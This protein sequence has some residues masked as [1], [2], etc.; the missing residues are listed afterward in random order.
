M[1]D[2]NNNSI[3]NTNMEF[4]NEAIQHLNETRKWTM[5]LAIVGFVFLGLMLISVLIALAT[6]SNR[7]PHAGI[8]G[9][10][11]FLLMLV[12]CAVYFSPIYCTTPLIFNTTVSS[13]ALL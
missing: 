2:L 4:G 12:F 9:G 11:A 1:D 10:F 7:F 8:A 6:G 5:S 13:V 3:E